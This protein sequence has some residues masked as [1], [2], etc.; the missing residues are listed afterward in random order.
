[1]NTKNCKT[2]R[3]QRVGSCKLA[4]DPDAVITCDEEGNREPPCPVNY[5]NCKQEL[6]PYVVKKTSP[7]VIYGS[8]AAGVAVLLTLL[9]QLTGEPS[10]QQ[11]MEAAAKELKQIW[12][13][14]QVP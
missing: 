2:F 1:M 7:M 9:F 8:I 12:P 6:K 13:W 11:R 5:P 4:D 10:E 3:C 14:L